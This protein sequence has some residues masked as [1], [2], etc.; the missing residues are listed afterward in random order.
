ML[1]SSSPLSAPS[2]LYCATDLLIRDSRIRLKMAAMATLLA[3]SSTAV[4]SLSFHGTA[5]FH[6][7]AF[8]CGIAFVFVICFFQGKEIFVESDIDGK[9][10]VPKLLPNLLETNSAL[11]NLLLL[12]PGHRDEMSS[13]QAI[14]MRFLLKNLSL[15]CDITEIMSE[16]NLGRFKTCSG[17]SMLAS[18]TA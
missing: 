17:P 13:H 11:R 14:L 9:S 10:E 5:N 18:T 8:I 3:P 2:V 4:A 7:S 1:L 16:R 12:L 6:S 15:H